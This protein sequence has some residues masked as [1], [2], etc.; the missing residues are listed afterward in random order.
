[1]SKNVGV[2]I[3]ETTTLPSSN[4]TT[5]S[6]GGSAFVL[7]EFQRSLVQDGK[8]VWEILGRRGNYDPATS[9]AAVEEPKLTLSTQS[10]EPAILTAGRAVLTMSGPNL[11]K[12]DLYDR[13]VL[14]YQD[15]TTLRTTRATYNKETEMVDIP[16]FVEIE[17]DVVFVSG[18][19]LSGNLITQDFTLTGGVRSVIKPRTTN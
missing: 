5:S 4:S 14:V 11:V 2:D 13:V 19:R 3:G 1:M 15:N 6:Q 10:G 7:N 8:T 17:N 18:E 9:S 12:A 16:V